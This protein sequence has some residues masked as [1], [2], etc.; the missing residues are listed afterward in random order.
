MCA[1]QRGHDRL[2]HQIGG[3]V[4]ESRQ[5]GIV[6]ERPVEF[7]GIGVDQQLGRIEPQAMIGIV[8]S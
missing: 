2:W 1:L 6:M 8:G 3:V 7:T 5:A 4:P